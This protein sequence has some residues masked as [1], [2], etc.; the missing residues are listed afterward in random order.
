MV[1]FGGSYAALYCSLCKLSGLIPCLYQ[2][3]SQCFSNDEKRNS[4]CYFLCCCN[5]S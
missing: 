2:L 3:L 5:F 1:A 4:K